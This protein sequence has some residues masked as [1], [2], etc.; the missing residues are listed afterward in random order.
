MVNLDNL[1]YNT[2]VLK[3]IR[4]V[5]ESKKILVYSKNS[6]IGVQNYSRINLYNLED[7]YFNLLQGN[8]HCLEITRDL[9]N[10]EEFGT[11]P[12]VYNCNNLVISGFDVI[13]YLGNDNTPTGYTEFINTQGR[14]SDYISI[15]LNFN[16]TLDKI[17]LELNNSLW[18]VKDRLEKNFIGKELNKYPSSQEVVSN[19]SKIPKNQK[20]TSHL[21]EFLCPINTSGIFLGYQTLL[22]SKEMITLGFIKDINIFDG[23]TYSNYQ[24]G[25]YQDDIVLYS[26]IYIDDSVGYYY[27]ITSLLTQQIYKYTNQVGDTVKDIIGKYNE[28]EVSKD[29]LYCSGKYIVFRINYSNYSIVA[30]FDTSCDSWVKSSEPNVIVDPLDRTSKIYELPKS[31]LIQSERTILDIIPE[32]SDVFFNVSEYIST[33]QSLDIIK[34]VGDWFVFRDSGFYIYSCPSMSVYMTK[35]EYD[36]CIV[37]N[38]NTI[39]IL[40]DTYY[41]LYHGPKRKTYYTEKARCLKGNY[42]LSDVEFYGDTIKMCQD[43]EQPEYLE[44]YKKS[45]VAIILKNKPLYETILNSY[46]RQPLLTYGIPNNIIGA[47][48]SVIFYLNQQNN[49]NYI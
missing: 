46:R 2:Y 20:Y 47:I 3:T 28:N 21:S 43:S 5:I 39:L 36:K 35:D 32:V 31:T 38:N 8:E 10:P 15:F 41:T 14:I 1:G 24:V 16:I 11:V 4:S 7:L 48:G 40:G 30:L 37:I 27:R 49:L 13:I 6:F 42:T 33:H 18:R 26:W 17:T 19:F 22:P 12:F 23:E 25:Y 45:E 34:K 44:Y 29:L 9:P